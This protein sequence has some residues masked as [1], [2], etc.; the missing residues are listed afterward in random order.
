V[1]RGTVDT[2]EEVRRLAKGAIAAG[3][4]GI[5][6]SPQ[7]VAVVRPL[8]PADGWI[9]VPGIRRAGD[10]AGDQARVAGPAEAAQAGAT[11]LV[12]GRPLLQAADPA[13]AVREFQEASR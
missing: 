4:K 9:V 1:G 3:L 10:A 7:E 11:H 13:A 2:G 5:V 6:C 8:V 12:V